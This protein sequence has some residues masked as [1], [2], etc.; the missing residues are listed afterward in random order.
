MRRGRSLGVVVVALAACGGG[1]GTALDD[2]RACRSMGRLLG[3]LASGADDA[4]TRELRRLRAVPG[5]PAAV[6]R[7]VDDLRVEAIDTDRDTASRAAALDDLVEVAD[8][9]ECDLDVPEVTTPAPTT[10]P[11]PT[12][13]S[14][15]ATGPDESAGVP[16][17]NAPVV[18]TVPEAEVPRPLAGT[19]TPTPVDIGAS[20]LPADVAGEIDG[21]GE[22]VAAAFLLDGMLVPA[23]PSA[24]TSVSVNASIYSDIYDEGFRAAMLELDVATAL[25]PDA[26]STSMRAAL[27]PLESY[28]IV[29][30]SSSEGTVATVGFRAEPVDR[31]A[32]LPTVDI[33]IATD[34]ARPGIVS[35]TIDHESQIDLAAFDVMTMP[36]ALIDEVGDEVVV[37]GSMGWELTSYWY[38]RNGALDPVL[39]ERWDDYGFDADV[40]GDLR[41]N[42]ALV[43]ATTGAGESDRTTDDDGEYVWFDVSG[44]KY[45]G[46]V[47]FDDGVLVGVYGY[48]PF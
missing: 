26:I 15:A 46:L 47:D 9:L 37:A 38:T 4:A 23:G 48:Q 17:T 44:Q 30:R 3:H 24:V 6:V 19:G 39:D 31:R 22:Q 27:A 13:D 40:R 34:S 33:D 11:P 32:G 14:A 16:T 42:T 20:A 43:E 8:E 28:T 25:P 35:L 18:T 36:Q 41:S 12:T 2:E 10:A 45:W 1:D 29:A 21:T 5:V 7:S